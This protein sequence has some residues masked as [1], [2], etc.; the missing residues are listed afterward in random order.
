MYRIDKGRDMVTLSISRVI[1]RTNKGIDRI[2]MYISNIIY[3]IVDFD[4]SLSK[5]FDIVHLCLSQELHM[6]KMCLTF[7]RI[8]ILD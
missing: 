8:H 1:Y 5:Q 6:I 4:V 3:F 7:I 2:T